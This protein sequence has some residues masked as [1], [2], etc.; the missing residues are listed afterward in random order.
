MDISFKREELNNNETI[1][2]FLRRQ[3][4]RVILPC[5]GMGSCGKCSITIH[6]KNSRKILKSIEVLSCQATASDIFQSSP[7][8]CS[9]IA[10][11][12]DDSKLLKWQNRAVLSKDGRDFLAAVD[13]GSTTIETAAISPDGDLIGSVRKRNPQVSYGADVISRIKAATAS[14]FAASDMQRLAESTIQASLAELSVKYGLSKAPLKMAIAANTTMGHLL[15]G[16]DVSSLGEAPFDSG[17]ISLKDI[18]RIFFTDGT[19]VYLLPGISA[20]VGGDITSGIYYLGIDQNSEPSMLVDLGT[21]GEMVIGNRAGLFVTSTA[22]GPAFE[23][24]NIS[25]G[26]PGLPGAITHVEF[27]GLKPVLTL[28][29]WE[30]D[31]SMLSPGEQMQ[32]QIKLRS[33]RP[34]GL[35]GN[36]LISAVSAMKK[37]GIIDDTGTYTDDKWIK[38]GFPLWKPTP[39]N[40]G[41]SPVTLT[42]DDIHELLFAKSAIRSGIEIL[43]K[44]SASTP[45]QV[46]L[47]GGF[48]SSL[49]PEEATA[50]GLLPGSISDITQAAGNTSLMGAIH[51]LTHD[52]PFERTRLSSIRSLSRDVT[53][54]S[55]PDFE[56]LYL[57]HLKL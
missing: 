38:D 50:I 43:I 56:E 41:A 5:G 30:D 42:Q 46:Y 32:Q 52:T 15:T 48:G 24:A 21:N 22:A 6:F 54:A 27:N 37:A 49:L 16:E 18:S 44:K 3:D 33:R 53:L 8:G 12:I 2:D 45:S 23:A 55:E 19:P 10:F 9:E 11:E 35:C 29:P 39:V 1:A 57:K 28:I 7:D 14:S 25:C 36:G 17:D 31:F 51:F 4:V 47:A 20:F 13:L 26:V 40:R 34:A